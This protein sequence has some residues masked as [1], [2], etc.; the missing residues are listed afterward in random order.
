MIPLL[1]LQGIPFVITTSGILPE[2]QMNLSSSSV[3]EGGLK[4]LETRVW[5]TDIGLCTYVGTILG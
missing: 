5:S 2:I 4:F 3:L 1:K